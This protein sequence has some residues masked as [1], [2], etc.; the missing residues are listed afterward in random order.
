MDLEIRKIK[1]SPVKVVSNGSGAIIGAFYY[2]RYIVPPFP[3]KVSVMVANE[4]FRE[5]K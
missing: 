2:G 1:D 4:L 3:E 5:G